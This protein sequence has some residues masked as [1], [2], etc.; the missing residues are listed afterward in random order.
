[1]KEETKAVRIEV[2]LI[3][4][5]RGYSDGSISDGIWAMENRIRGEPGVRV[6][7]GLGVVPTVVQAPHDEA[8]WERLRGEVKRG[9][10]AVLDGGV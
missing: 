10:D 9:L 4:V 8:Y 2:P 6:V 3:A 7:D 1:M 5:I